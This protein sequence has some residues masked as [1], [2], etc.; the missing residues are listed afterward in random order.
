M[1][2]NLFLNTS[3]STSLTEEGTTMLNPKLND[4]P[5]EVALMSNLQQIVILHIYQ[6]PGDGLRLWQIQ[7]RVGTEPKDAIKSALMELVEA[8]YIDI[9]S[10]GGGPKYCRRHS[11][12]Y[13]LSALSSIMGA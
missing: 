11:K 9:I 8:G 6:T 5:K 13:L 2:F 10:T 1:E 3:Q 7:N 12:M 4:G